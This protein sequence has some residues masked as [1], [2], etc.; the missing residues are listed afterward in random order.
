[1]YRFAS[2]LYLLRIPVVATVVYIYL[3][4]IA[5]LMYS[6]KEN[7]ITLINTLN[8]ITLRQ[9]A[10]CCERRRIIDNIY[11]LLLYV[12]TETVRDLLLV[13]AKYF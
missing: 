13:K 12:A 3:N 2:R 5:E 4:I 11:T 6:V 10:R 8:G 1:M 9:K 7:H